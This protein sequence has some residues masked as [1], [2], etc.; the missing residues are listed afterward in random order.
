LNACW[1]ISLMKAIK[2]LSNI[3][4]K[5]LYAYSKSIE[6]IRFVDS[7]HIIFIEGDNYSKLFRGLDAPFAD[8]LVYSSQNYIL[9]GFGPG[10]YPG[11]FGVYKA[12]LLDD[13]GYWDRNRQVKEFKAHEG[14]QYTEKY[15]VTL[16]VGESGAQYKGPAE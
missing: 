9:A 5:V 6:G 16:W 7:R 4:K 10:N 3:K 2:S 11:K 15:N 1:T 14:T 8:N 13:E 12:D